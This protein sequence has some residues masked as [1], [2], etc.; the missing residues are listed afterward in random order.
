MRQERRR[1]KLFDVTVQFNEKTY[2]IRG[3]DA[4]S[5]RQANYHAIKKFREQ[6][7][8][9]DNAFVKIKYSTEK[10]RT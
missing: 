5:V 8:L 2:T 7:R 4:V 6:H 10:Q 3:V 9:P 1:W